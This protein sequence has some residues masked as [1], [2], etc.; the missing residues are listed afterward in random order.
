MDFQIKYREY[1]TYTKQ[2]LVQIILVLCAS[3]KA[4]HIM[5]RKQRV[6]VILKY[7]DMVECNKEISNI[8][9]KCVQFLRQDE[10]STE[11]GSSNKD[12]ILTLPAT[13][14]ETKIDDTLLLQ[15]I[16]Y[17]TPTYDDVD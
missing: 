9:N 7:M 3:N 13:T 1:D 10:Y 16:Q 5:L 11:E 4:M 17:Y 12:A 8:I 15:L 6:Y 2:Y 14:E